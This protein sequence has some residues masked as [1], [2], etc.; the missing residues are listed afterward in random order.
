MNDDFN[1]SEA[2]AILFELAGEINKA[3]GPEKLEERRDLARELKQLAKLLGLLERPAQEFLQASGGSQTAD[4]DTAA[5]EAAIQARA[6]AKQGKDF[7][8]A[9]QIRQ[10]LLAE[11]IVLE[12]KPGGV[13]LWRRA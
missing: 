4:N 12:D 2:I 7:A 13:T 11:G 10:D 1:T 3:E 6:D 9:D 8:K 5:I